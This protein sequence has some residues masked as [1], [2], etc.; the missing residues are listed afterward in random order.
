[1]VSEVGC[2]LFTAQITDL[3]NKHI[4]AYI[5][6]VLDTQDLLAEVLKIVEGGLSSDGVHQQEALSVLHVQIS[7]SCELFLNW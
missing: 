5:I 3:M 7:H 2:L 1:M 6:S 4:G